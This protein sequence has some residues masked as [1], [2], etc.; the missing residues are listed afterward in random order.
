MRKHI[1]L[2]RAAYFAAGAIATACLLGGAAQAITNTVFRYS[3]P[4]RGYLMLDPVGF[5][6]LTNEGPG[7]YN[8][9]YYYSGGISTTAANSCFGKS[10]ELPQGARLTSLQVWYKKRVSVT[11]L[12]HKP[13]DGSVTHLVDKTFA[14]AQAT[15]RPANTV[16]VA[17][18]NVKTI[19]NQV[20]GYGLVICLPQTAGSFYGARVT[21]SYQTA[22]D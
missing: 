5:V 20:F 9:F 12:R 16:I 17:G 4:Q 15:I 14:T 13:S 21:Y 7:S 1:T 8:I 10:I 11:L 2:R 18:P 22:G 6:P 3:T 19:N